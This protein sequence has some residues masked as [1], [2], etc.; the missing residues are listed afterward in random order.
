MRDFTPSAE[1]I[2]LSKIPWTYNISVQSTK[3][4]TP[5]KKKRPKKP[6]TDERVPQMVT[7]N[8]LAELTELSA[9][10]MYGTLSKMEK[11]GLIVFEREEEK[12]KLYR[13]TELGKEILHLEIK[14]IE[15]LYKNSKGEEINE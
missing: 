14:R 13:I 11:D 2:I 6:P 12:R 8:Q 9:G 4:I 15:R 3:A 1:D 7:V 10:T 5:E